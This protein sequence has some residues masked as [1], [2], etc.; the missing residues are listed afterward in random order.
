MGA[1]ELTESINH[2]F[3]GNYEHTIDTYYFG[4]F[5]Q[6][7]S[8]FRNWPCEQ[9][10]TEVGK[11]VKSRIEISEMMMNYFSGGQ[12][13]GNDGQRPSPDAMRKMGADINT[14]AEHAYWQLM[15]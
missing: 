3:R 5:F 11:F 2:T 10:Q 8:L 15:I 7:L 6:Y 13:Y 14:K 12:Q 9:N 1:S 4:N